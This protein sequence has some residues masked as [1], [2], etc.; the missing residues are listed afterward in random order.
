[1]QVN[2]TNGSGQPANTEQSQGANGKQLLDIVIGQ[3]ANDIRTGGK[4]GQQIMQTFAVGRTGV[5]R[6]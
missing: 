4:V 6:G 5:T 2:I 3:V 1:M